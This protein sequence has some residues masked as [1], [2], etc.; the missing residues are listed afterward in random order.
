VLLSDFG[1]ANGYAAI[2][3]GVVLS[4][5]PTLRVYDAAHD[6]RQF[7]ITSAAYVLFT[8]ITAFPP[9]TVFVCVVDPGVGGT[10]REVIAA[11]DRRFVIAPDNGLLTLCAATA[12]EF[13]PMRARD[14]VLDELSRAK[15]PNSNTFDGRDLFSPLGA[16]LAAHGLEAVAGETC[17][18]IERD[19]LRP[20]PAFPDARRAHVAAQVIHVDSFGNAITNVR[21]PG[22]LGRPAPLGRARCN[23]QEYPVCHAFSDRAPG[24]PLAYWGSFGFLELAVSTGSAHDAYGLDIGMPVTLDLDTSP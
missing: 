22:E 11:V 12:A 20:V 15:P 4:Y 10:R 1:T 5:D 17:D 21:L 8:V 7:S 9:E 23:G 6:I 14:E 19:E 2:M 13:L 18:P 16:R 24:D 3:R